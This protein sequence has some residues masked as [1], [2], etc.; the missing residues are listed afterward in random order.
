GT[1]AATSKRRD[2]GDLLPG[3][4]ASNHGISGMGGNVGSSA[5]SS[6][7][8]HFALR[9]RAPRRGWNGNHST[10][11]ASFL[12][13]LRVSPRLVALRGIHGHPVAIHSLCD[14]SGR[15][16]HGIRRLVARGAFRALDA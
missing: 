4:F 3:V 6:W 13:L 1:R 15:V 9:G 10:S 7:G 8:V 11:A 2:E 12:V 14:P 16:A 5:F